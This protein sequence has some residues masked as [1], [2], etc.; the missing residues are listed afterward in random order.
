LSIGFS[1]MCAASA[2][3]SAGWPRRAGCGTCAPIDAIC[4]SDRPPSSGVWNRPGAIVITRIF[5]RARSL[6]IGRVMPTIPPL[7]AE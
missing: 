3:Y 6:A 1:T 7:D 4:S 5:S 2:A